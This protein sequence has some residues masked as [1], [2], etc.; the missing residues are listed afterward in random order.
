MGS[1]EASVRELRIRTAAGAVGRGPWLAAYPEER[2][3]HT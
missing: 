1:E 3:I 2:H